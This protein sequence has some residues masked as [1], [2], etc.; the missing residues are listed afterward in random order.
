METRKP[1]FL[2]KGIVIIKALIASQIIYP[3]RI[4]KV[5]NYVVKVLNKTI[6][7]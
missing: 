2:W 6:F 1:N 7:F 5:P 3:A 4:I